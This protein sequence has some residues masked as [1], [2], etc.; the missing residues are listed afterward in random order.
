MKKT[1]CVIIAVVIALSSMT[2]ASFAATPSFSMTADKTTDLKL[3]DSIIVTVKLGKNSNLCS[4]TLDL[5]YDNNCFE[6]VS[7][8][9]KYSIPSDKNGGIVVNKDYAE[10]KGRYVIVFEGKL[11]GEAVLFTAELKVKRLGGTFSLEASEVKCYKNLQLTEVTDDINDSLK[12]SAV[13]IVCPHTDKTTTVV[14]NATCYAE[15]KS[16]ELCNGCGMK[17]EITAEKLPHELGE[18]VIKAPK[19]EET[20]IK[21]QQCAKC[22]YMGEETEIP[23]TGHTEGDWRVAKLPTTKETGLEEKKCTVCGKVLDSREIPMLLEYT[24][25]DVNNDG[26]IT[27]VDARCI[28]RYVAGLD[29]LT[30]AQMLAADINLNGDVTAVDARIILQYVAGLLKF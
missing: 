9:P 27:A 11:T 7:L 30:P 22:D 29:K 12:S 26:Y 28:L 24:L 21:A 20:G 18:Y 13:T 4:A 1:L 3:G 17:T 10:N 19:C 16:E 6:L 25:G 5:V 8:E 23:A 14:S 2:V 15:G